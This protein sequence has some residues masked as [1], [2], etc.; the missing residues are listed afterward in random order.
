MNI[1]TGTSSVATL[2]RCWCGS[3]DAD[4]REEGI[5]SVTI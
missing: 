2:E 5:R 3:A 4:R 1:A